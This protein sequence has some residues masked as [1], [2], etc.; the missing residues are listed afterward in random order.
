[1]DQYLSKNN[2]DQEE[3][4]EEESVDSSQNNLDPPNSSKDNNHRVSISASL[5]GNNN[6]GNGN[7]ES[8]FYEYSPI[9]EKATQVDVSS[10]SG[11][12]NFHDSS[13]GGEDTVPSISRQVSIS[14]V[15]ETTQRMESLLGELKNLRRSTSEQKSHSTKQNR[16]S[17]YTSGSSDYGGYDFQH[18]EPS[19]QQQQPTLVGGGVKAPPTPPEM[20]SSNISTSWEAPPQKQKPASNHSRSHS[21]PTATANMATH[22]TTRPLSLSPLKQQQQNMSQPHQTSQQHDA[23]PQQ[24]EI[25]DLEGLMS[26]LEGYKTRLNQLNSDTDSPNTSNYISA[27]TSPP[28]SYS[29]I[30]QPPSARPPPTPV[31]T[32]SSSKPPSIPPTWNNNSQSYTTSLKEEMDHILDS[33]PIAPFLSKRKSHD[34]SADSYTTAQSPNE[35]Q[36]LS[37]FQRTETGDISQSSGQQTVKGE[38]NSNSKRMSSPI[39]ESLPQRS[40]SES[41]TRQKILGSPVQDEAL[42]KDENREQHRKSKHKHKKREKK[43]GKRKEEDYDEEKKSHNKSPQQRPFSQPNIQHLMDLSN[44]SFR[45]DEIDLPPDERHLLEKFIDALSKLSV[46]INMDERKKVE[47]KRRLQNALRAIEGWI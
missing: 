8:S 16:D 31:S 46:E 4:E 18:Y 10:S 29:K 19:K 2:E 11:Y 25:D 41:A 21:L 27:P 17:A 35:P 20:S 45:L 5:A 12:P 44:N 40:V 6:N 24:Q 43:K 22:T 38:D 39:L 34:S 7:R 30:G 9:I 13:S 23:H 36:Q 33:P 14:M 32:T 42:T 28:E 26:S 37:E 3:E 1:M 15:R 47:G